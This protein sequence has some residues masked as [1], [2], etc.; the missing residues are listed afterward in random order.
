MIEIE[1]TKENNKNK[2]KLIVGQNGKTHGRIDQ[3]RVSF[4]QKYSTTLH[5]IAEITMKKESLKL[6]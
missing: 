5:K 2:R 6:V 1:S 3:R 4:I